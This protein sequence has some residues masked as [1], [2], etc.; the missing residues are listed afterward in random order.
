MVNVIV[1]FITGT[2]SALGIGGGSVLMTYLAVAGYGHFDAV[3]IN[4]TYFICCAVPVAIKHIKSG[5][6]ALGEILPAAIPAC[7]ASVIISIAVSDMDQDMLRKAFGFFAIAAGVRE[8][9]KKHK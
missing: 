9:F 7:A 4:L 8:I 2:V 6:I 3:G 5:L 1:G